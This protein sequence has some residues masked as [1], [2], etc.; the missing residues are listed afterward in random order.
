MVW[1]TDQGHNIAV[2]LLNAQLLWPTQDLQDRGHRHLAR[3]GEGLV[4][5]HFSLG[6]YMQLTLNG[7]ET[8][9]DILFSDVAI[10]EGSILL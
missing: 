1:D 4:G 8:E 7:A 6:V 3:T 10:G 9:A 5:P 2:I